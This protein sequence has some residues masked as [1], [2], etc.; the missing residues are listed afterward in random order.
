MLTKW[1]FENAVHQIFLMLG[2]LSQHYK[3]GE[4][5]P[6]GELSQNSYSHFFPPPIFA[7]SDIVPGMATVFWSECSGYTLRIKIH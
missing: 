5:S 6:S 3:C 7:H 1:P 4:E 2:R